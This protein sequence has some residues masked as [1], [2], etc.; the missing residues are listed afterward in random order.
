MPSGFPYFHVQFGAGLGYAHVIENE[1]DF[2]LQFGHEVVAGMLGIDAT[3][4]K[5][6]KRKPVEAEREKVK[7]FLQHWQK[8]DWTVELDGGE[9]LP[10]DIRG[11]VVVEG[12]GEGERKREGEGEREGEREGKRGGGLLE[13]RDG[14]EPM[15]L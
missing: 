9:Y 1:S 11:A 7:S 3:V 2:P 4:F 14:G 5:Y 12:E 10:E 8:F 13:E 15:Q 6:P